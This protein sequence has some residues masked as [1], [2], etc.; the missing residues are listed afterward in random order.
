M[1]LLC[2]SFIIDIVLLVVCNVNYD[3]LIH[4]TFR[5]FNSSLTAL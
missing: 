3:N 1:S 5:A 4:T 2:S